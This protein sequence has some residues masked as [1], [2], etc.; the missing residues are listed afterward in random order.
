[1]MKNLTLFFVLFLLML[2]YTNAQ[3]QN[4]TKMDQE[5]Q[6]VK[7]AVDQF[8]Q[9]LGALFTGDAEPMKEVWSHA[10]DVTYL[11]PAGGIREGWSEVEADWEAQAA[12]KLGGNI[13]P[14]NFRFIVGPRISVVINEENG[15]NVDP[16][17]NPVPVSIRATHI[18][19]KEK[20]KWK[21]VG[22]HVDP[23]PFL[24]SGTK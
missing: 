2:G 24:N 11:S 7:L 23:L 16:N 13:S 8:Y 19:R 4:I 20:G 22:D 3:C 12:L 9:A 18:F 17:G 21:M 6:A 14:S 10:D 5:K 1:M 15:E